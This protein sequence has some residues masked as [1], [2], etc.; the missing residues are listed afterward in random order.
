MRF[1]NPTLAAVQ[2]LADAFPSLK[3][4]GANDIF[5]RLFLDYLPE[6]REFPLNPFLSPQQD[7]IVI[8]R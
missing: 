8:F 3:K 2:I 7:C 5:S 6:H 1:E 4:S